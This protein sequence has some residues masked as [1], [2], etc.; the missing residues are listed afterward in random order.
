MLERGEPATPG[1]RGARPDLAAELRAALDDFDEARAQAALDLV[2]ARLSSMPLPATS[3]PLPPRP[4]R[5]VGAGRGSVAQEHFAS[6]VLRGRLLALARGWDRGAGPRA[7]LACAPGE[8]H[9]LGL[10]VFGLALRRTAG[11]SYLGPDTPVDTLG[12]ASRELVP[13]VVV[14]TALTAGRLRPLREPLAD[15][16]RGHTS[17]SRA[18]AHARTSPPRSAPRGC[19][20]IRW[21]PPPCSPPERR[22]RRE[23]VGPHLTTEVVVPGTLGRRVRLLLRRAQPR[24]DHAAVVALPAAG[25]ARW[26]CA[27]AR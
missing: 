9:D 8:R 13:A 6:I 21:R 10:I 19:A 14:V 25:R 5:A 22:R 12:A 3:P 1:P 24:G 18:R 16:A 15:L 7:L 2:L 26:R 4:W 23:R 17:C 20:A 11:A 27:R